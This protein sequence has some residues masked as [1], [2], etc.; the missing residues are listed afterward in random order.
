[1]SNGEDSVAVA[2]Q[3]LIK[4]LSNTTQPKPKIFQVDDRLRKVN[5]KDYEPRIVALGPIH[6]GKAHLK[7]MEQHK[8]RFLQQLL[9]RRGDLT[10]AK[11]VQKVREMEKTALQCYS[12]PLNV[13]ADE[14]V[15]MLLLDGCFLIELVRRHKHVFEVS[16]EKDPVF[17]PKTLSQITHDLMLFENQLPFSILNHLFNMIKTEHPD[18]NL[19]DLVVFL[20][21]DTFP[22]SNALK[23]D[24]ASDE[25][26]HL[27][28]DQDHLLG[29]IY[30]SFTPFSTQTL[31]TTKDRNSL[32][33]INSASELKEAGIRLKRS[34]QNLLTFKARVLKFPP[35][36]V[37]GETESL[38][39]NLMAYEQ[40][41][42]DDDHPKHVTDYAFFM[43]CLIRSTKDI[44][45]LR[46]SGIISNYLGGDDN[47]CLMF[48]RLG[49]NFLIRSSNFCYSDVFVSLNKHCGRRHN[50]WMAKLRRNY[51]N[52]PWSVIKFVAAAVLLLLTLTQTVFA[53]LAYEQR[54]DVMRVRLISM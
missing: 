5:A 32:A 35:L 43:H 40:L 48:N 14:F 29:L 47:I 52:S 36:Q 22:W 17:E 27:H 12:T 44:E 10:I 38:L 39:R 8:Q 11:L 46:C 21:N 15:K 2:I 7:E 34:K 37:S 18:E 50:K 28:P 4:N 26:H 6:R 42:L 33:H 53:I 24:P 54:N 23:L 9:Q 25:N 31:S 16:T 45:I 1:M 49:T 3:G 51:F 41:C 20:V 30:Q 13:D 19:H